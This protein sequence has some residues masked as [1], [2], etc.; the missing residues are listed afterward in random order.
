M[1]VDVKTLNSIPLSFR[2]RVVKSGLLISKSEELR[3]RFI[4][5]TLMEYLDFKPIEER[6]IE[7]IL[8]K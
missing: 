7:E 8:K 6:I 3:L 5:K 2:Y 4:K 1:P